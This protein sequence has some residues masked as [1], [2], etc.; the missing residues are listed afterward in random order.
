MTSIID[1]NNEPLCV[2]DIVIVTHIDSMGVCSN[3]G[4]AV[5]VN[6]RWTTYGGGD[7]VENKVF[8]TYIMGWKGIDFNKDPAEYLAQKIKSF[9][10]VVDGEHWPAFGIN[11]KIDAL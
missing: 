9:A 7:N 8:D 6:D 11:Y 2:G 3:H 10:D 5:V 4:P 1:L